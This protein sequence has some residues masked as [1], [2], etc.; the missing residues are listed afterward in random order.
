[1]QMSRRHTGTPGFPIVWGVGH[2]GTT[3]PSF[4]S[5]F[6][7]P[8][9]FILSIFASLQDYSRQL[10]YQMNSFTG[11]SWH[12]FK[13]PMLPPCIDLSPPPPPPPHQIL[14]SPPT[15]VLN[16]CGKPWEGGESDQTYV[17]CF[18]VVTLLSKYIQGLGEVSYILLIWAYILCRWRP[19][20]C[21][22]QNVA[23]FLR[24][25]N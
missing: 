11:I 16:T 6:Q 5:F 8:R 7:K 18:S 10:Y 21:F 17:Y 20:K 15:H 3:S 9:G 24:E 22:R 19:H 25:P 13:P 12:Y 4:Y 23:S 1:M 2:G 14:K